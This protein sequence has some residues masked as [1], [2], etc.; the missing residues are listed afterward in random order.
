MVLIAS[1]LKGLLSF[2]EA[3]SVEGPKQDFSRSRC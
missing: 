2:Q 1:C 3:L